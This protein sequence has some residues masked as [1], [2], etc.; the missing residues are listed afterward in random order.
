MD[1]SIK[2]TGSIQ[3]NVAISSDRNLKTD[4]APVNKQEILSRLLDLPISYWRFTNEVSEVRHLGPTAQDFGAQF[5][6]GSDDKYIRAVDANGVALVSIQALHEKIA[7]QEQRI[8]ELEKIVLHLH[9]TFQNNRE[10]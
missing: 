1:G 5:K 8:R 3:A 6:V 2:A 10:K 4:F 9:Q 7:D